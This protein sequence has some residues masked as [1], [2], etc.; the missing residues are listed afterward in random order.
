M[1][2]NSKIKMQNAKLRSETRNEDFMMCNLQR[3]GFT[4]VELM[5]TLVILVITLGA[6]YTTYIAQQRSFTTQDQITESQTESK[7]AF[8]ILTKDLRNA[9]YAYPVSVNPAISGFTN[10]INPSENNNAGRDALTLVSGSVQIATLALP[11]IIGQNQIFITYTGNTRFNVPNLANFSID[12]IDF[13]VITTCAPIGATSDCADGIANALTLNRGMS[14][15]IPAG[16]PLY[17]LAASTYCI[18]TNTSDAD[19][20]DLR[21]IA[22]IATLANCSGALPADVNRIAENIEDI[23][24]AYAIDS[25]SD[26]LIDDQNGNSAFDPGDYLLPAQFPPNSKIMAV[27]VSILAVTTGDDLSINP[28]SKP[29]YSSGIILEENNFS[30]SVRTNLDN[31]RLSRKIWSMEVALRNP[32]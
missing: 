22:G 30:G 2:L 32:R 28:S 10:S 27:R 4:I 18:V 13:S 23:Q 9:G 16:R 1:K 8:N 25:N 7:I 12:G 14:K 19:Y 31:D 24:F 6:V 20:L 3:A 5:V 17:A 29:Y 21:K 11:L 26:G 15:P